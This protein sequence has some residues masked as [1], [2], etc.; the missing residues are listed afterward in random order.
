MQFTCN[1]PKT[2]RLVKL[3]VAGVPV[4]LSM[5]QNTK[6]ANYG[7]YDVIRGPQKCEFSQKSTGWTFYERI[8]MFGPHFDRFYDFSC[9]IAIM[10]S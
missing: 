6:I 5:G 8:L 9:F 10:T 3:R 4:V 2:T 1:I 7:V